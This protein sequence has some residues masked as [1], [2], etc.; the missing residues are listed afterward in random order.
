[1]DELPLVPGLNYTV[2]NSTN[3]MTYW[4]CVELQSTD[5]LFV[6]SDTACDF[7]VNL[8]NKEKAVLQ[9]NAENTWTNC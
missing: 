3:A 7:V 4:I 1:M 9:Q 2:K 6:W 5:K 8:F